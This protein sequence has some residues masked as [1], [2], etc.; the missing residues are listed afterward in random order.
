MPEFIVS[1]ISAPIIA[2]SS[3][4]INDCLEWKKNIDIKSV[5]IKSVGYMLIIGLLCY[6]FSVSLAKDGVS[7]KYLVATYIIMFGYMPPL[8]IK[9]LDLLY[10]KIIKL[11]TKSE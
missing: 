7:Y 9:V 8:I 1:V 6:P 5:S 11:N 2:I 3:C 4:I 10:R